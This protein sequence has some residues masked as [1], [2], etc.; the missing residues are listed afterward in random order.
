MKKSK[1]TKLPCG[2]KK[3]FGILISSMLLVNVFGSSVYASSLDNEI[4]VND[5]I[6][7][8]TNTNPSGGD[9]TNTNPN[10]GDNTDTNT[11]GGDNTN[12]NPNGGDNTDTSTNGGDNTNTN[13]NGGDNTNTNP[14]IGGDNTIENNGNGDD[15]LEGDNVIVDTTAPSISFD[16]TKTVIDLENRTVIFYGLVVGEGEED[17]SKL[18]FSSDGCVWEDTFFD[19]SEFEE[20]ENAIRIAFIVNG[21]FS[22]TVYVYD[23]AGNEASIPLNIV[24][25][26]YISDETG[27]EKQEQPESSH[28]LLDGSSFISFSK[29]NVDKTTGTTASNVAIYPTVSGIV[30][31]ENGFFWSTNGTYTAEQ[32]STAIFKSTCNVSVKSNGTFWLYV[33]SADGIF[34]KASVTVDNIDPNFVKTNYYKV[35]FYDYKGKL[36]SSVQVAEGDSA[37]APEPEVREGYNF[38]GWSASFDN[39]TKN[40]SV[41]SRYTKAVATPTASP[42]KATTTLKPATATTSLNKA[43]SLNSLNSGL[44]T[45]TGTAKPTKSPVPNNSMEDQIRKLGSSYSL[46]SFYSS[47]DKKQNDNKNASDE[48]DEKESEPILLKDFITEAKPLE[49]SIYDNKSLAETKNQKIGTGLANSVWEQSGST[50]ERTESAEYA[51]NNDNGM[52]TGRVASAIVLIGIGGAIAF[53]FLNRKFYW[54]YLPF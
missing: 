12:T 32:L 15:D 25:S 21:D 8:N 40:I 51:E 54:V 30:L 39:V 48:K 19:G 16:S 27:D 26:D 34:Y 36:I 46:N 43:T 49:K 14:P 50:V 17:L 5:G 35:N 28:S 45:S 29:K 42:L 13:P 20:T 2:K 38:S 33:K 9:N 24:F 41:Y 47:M 53:Y 4:L 22:A 11:N 7:N 44:S 18:S 3:M 6:D 1:L 31:D 23:E 10:G 37:I 52:S